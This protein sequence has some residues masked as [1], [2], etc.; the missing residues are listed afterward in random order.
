VALVTGAAGGI[1]R[2][3]ALELAGRGAAVMV[4][5]LSE[6]V[7][8]TEQAIIAA[9]GIAAST[10]GDVGDPDQAKALVE[11][12]VQR[13]GRLDIAHNN[14]GTSSTGLLA[15]TDP[16][17]FER[18]IRTNLIGVFAC[19]RYELPPMLE[20]GA[21]AIVNTASV[22]SFS[23]SLGKAAYVASKHG[24]A[25]L[26]RTGALDHGGSGVRINAVA[27]GP[28]ATAMTAAVPPERMRGIV[29]RTATG[30]MGQPEEI[31]RA[32]VWL[33]SDEASYINGAILAVDGGWLAS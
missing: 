22:W 16:V 23:G 10:L 8:Q 18:V 4:S 17:E 31:A 14:A 21:G 15:D 20:A 32:V 12:T 3:T 13:F 11:R 25:G 2:A 19:M 28:I 9:G 33:C 30:R 24:V 29:A 7:L 5:D 26:T 27:P 1:G 6:A